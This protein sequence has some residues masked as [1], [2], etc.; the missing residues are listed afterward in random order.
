VFNFMRTLS[1]KSAMGNPLVIG[2]FLLIF[3]YAVIKRSKPV[4]LFLFAVVSIM[5]L[6]RFTLPAEPGNELTLSSTIPF[7]FGGLAIGAAL[8]YFMFI[9]GD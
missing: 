9:K 4:L 5:F 2:L 6:V 7:A 8:I 1:L 3:F